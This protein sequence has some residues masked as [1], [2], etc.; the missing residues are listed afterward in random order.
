VARVGKSKV[1]GN[2]LLKDLGVDMRHIL[3]WLVHKLILF[4]LT[5]VCTMMVLVDV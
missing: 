5:N 3:I 2:V 1:E 4:L